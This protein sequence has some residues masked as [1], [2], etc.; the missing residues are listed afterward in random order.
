V[1]T[2]QPRRITAARAGVRFFPGL[3]APV[4][5]HPWIRPV[6]ASAQARRCATPYTMDSRSIS[7]RHPGIISGSV[8]IDSIIGAIGR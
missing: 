7:G 2:T 3:A 4:G 1:T 6:T 5:T 8:S